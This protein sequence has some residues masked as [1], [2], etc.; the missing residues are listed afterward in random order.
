MELQDVLQYLVTNG[1]VLASKEKGYV[2]SK[3]FQEDVRKMKAGQKITVNMSVVPKSDPTPAAVADALSK[4]PLELIPVI[5]TMATWEDRFL[6]FIRDA[7][8]P[9]RLESSRMESYAVNKYS[10]EGMKA[11]RAA[12]EAGVDYGL[13]VKSTK[14]YYKSTVKFKKTIGNYMAQG[15]WRSDY[16][17][18]KEVAETGDVNKLNEH[19]KQETKSNEHTP[20]R[21]G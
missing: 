8:V 19:V 5:K 11:F 3:K 14:L 13:L 9:Q 17:N 21:L 15:D 7:E 4:V 6:K 12:I 18:L 1:Y 10:V 2:L 20:Y 16:N